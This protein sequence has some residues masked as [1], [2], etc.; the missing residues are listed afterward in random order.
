[1]SILN[2]VSLEH[3]TKEWFKHLSDGEFYEFFIK[4]AS[5][6][7]R[8]LIIGQ[9]GTGTRTLGESLLIMN[10]NYKSYDFIEDIVNAK[11]VF[12]INENPYIVIIQ[13]NSVESALK[14]VSEYKLEFDYAIHLLN[15]NQ[16]G[17]IKTIKYNGECFK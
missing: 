3:K 14:R 16:I 7:K 9:L 17:T 4:V 5:K 11:R 10:K 1:M 13:D 8:I 15:A 2:K 6:S 12:P